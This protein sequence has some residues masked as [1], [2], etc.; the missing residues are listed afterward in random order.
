MGF[1]IIVT[2]A[3]ENTSL[4]SE[5]C[6]WRFYNLPSPLDIHL[7]GWGISPGFVLRRGVFN[8][9]QHPS[10]LHFYSILLFCCI[11]VIYT[12]IGANFNAFPS[13]SPIFLSA[14]TYYRSI[15]SIL[16][17]QTSP[18]INAANTLICIN[19]AWWVV[20]ALSGSLD[21]AYS[22]SK[23]GYNFL[24]LRGHRFGRK[25]K[26]KIFQRSAQ[27]TDATLYT[28]EGFLPAQHVGQGY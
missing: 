23:V 11:C 7:L 19:S 4:V 15:R 21:W 12:L 1:P 20:F 17:S 16:P 2:Y 14:M 3:E 25:N 22:Y 26:N 9:G 28:T 27:F 5:H 10:N 18:R 6:V 8:H 24:Y 13:H